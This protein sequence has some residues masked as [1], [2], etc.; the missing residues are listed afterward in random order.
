MSP[1]RIRKRDQFKKAI[2]GE[3]KN[4]LDPSIFHKLS[5]VA[6]LAWVGI[7]ADGLSSAC[8]GPEE[9]FLAIGSHQFLCFFLALA[10]AGTVFIISL[11]FSQI[12]EAFPEGGGG[13]LVSTKLLGKYPGL[14]AGAALVVDY[15]L[16]ISISLACAGDAIF[17][18]LPHHYLP[19]KMHFEVFLVCLLIYLNL[20]GVKES[21][22]VLMPIFLTFLITHVV[23]LIVV[24][25]S[26]APDL[27]HIAQSQGKQLATELGTVG[28]FP[29]L[30]VFLRAYGLGAGTYTGIEAVSNSMYILKEPKVET[31]KKTMMYMAISLSLL[32]GGILLGYLLVGAK[33]EPGKTLNATLSSI[34]THGWNLPGL[35]LG[36]I[37]TT[38]TMFAEAALLFVAAQAGFMGGPAVLSYMAIDSWVPKR[39]TYLSD[40]LVTKNGILIIGLAALALLVYAKGSVK[41]LVVMYSINVFIDF[42]LAL[43]GITVYRIQKKG[44][45]WIR[46][47]INTSSGALL[48]VAILIMMIVIKFEEGAWVT[49]LIT[50][51]LIVV[52][53]LI[54]R[55]YAS[56]QKALQRLDEILTDIPF[57]QQTGPMPQYDPKGPTAAIL[58]TGYN[59]LGIHSLLAIKQI[60]RD[61]FK[62]YVFV[63]V[64]V[65][66]SSKF[67]GVDEIEALKMSTEDSLKKYKALTDKMG[68]YSDYR[69]GMG[70]DVIDELVEISQKTVREF[71]HV[72]FFGGQ[73]VFHEENMFSRILH[74]QTTILLQKR[75]HFGGL[76]MVVLPIRVM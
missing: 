39:F 70:T 62:N 71:K 52:C 40:R 59:G 32:A 44:K 35:P 19:Y 30:L 56:V 45:A 1:E 8:Y 49:L 43:T 41:I 25:A 16:T 5:L 72:V 76:P 36:K 28:F 12:I 38:I 67:K 75:F 22:M 33:A 46:K 27:G 2:L 4:P 47:V 14:I 13:Y 29:L 55:H 57:P 17:S 73:L 50:S 3:E 31:G 20:R 18:F 7:G 68:M 53:I 64:G 48:S 60:F 58:V 21:V 65:I 66:D 24:F 61:Y 9:A 23:L 6:F 51:S 63:S 26:H 42:A 37:F 69:Y 11:G 34:A 74:N 54:H 15:V 10:T